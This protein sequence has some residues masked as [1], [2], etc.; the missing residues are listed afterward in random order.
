MERLL[1][2]GSWTGLRR[3]LTVS[4]VGENARGKLRGSNASDLGT[5]ELEKPRGGFGRLLAPAQ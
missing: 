2:R 1:G 5:E 4:V 3:R